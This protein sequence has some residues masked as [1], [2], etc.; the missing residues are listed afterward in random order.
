MI[1]YMAPPPEFLFPLQIL[2]ALLLASLM[3]SA[4]VMW[5]LRM[6]NVGGTAGNYF[7]M[8]FACISMYAVALI[9]QISARTEAEATIWGVLALLHGITGWFCLF[10]AGEYSV[11]DSPRP[12]RV[13]TVGTCYGM[14]LGGFIYSL[15]I[16]PGSGL[17]LVSYVAGYGWVSHV[18]LLFT[19]VIILS[20]FLSN[21]RFL[22]FV[23]KGYRVA[24]NTSFGRRSRT[25][26]VTLSI[27]LWIDF[28]TVG[29]G[30]I[31]WDY[32]IFSP[33]VLS[34]VSSVFII[35]AFFLLFRE[36]RIIYF[37]AQKAIGIIVLST[38]GVVYFDHKFQKEIE[39]N[40]IREFLGP[41]LTAVNNLVQETLDLAAIEWIREFQTDKMTFLLDVRAQYDIIGLLLV[42][43]PTQILRTA[44]R[45]FMDNLMILYETTKGELCDTPEKEKRIHEICVKA[46]P[47]I[48]PIN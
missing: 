16:S 36:Y 14:A 37:M 35:V 34:I 31:F 7:T 24:P 11:T 29:A 33:V 18:T 5:Y 12:M 39:N 26:L 17:V 15:L 20:G 4:A 1:M 45:K 19:L 42:S 40:A 32:A 28:I 22:Q 47:F 8:F 25:L 21:A 44:F 27:G 13:M 41:A 43:T 23:I 38:E 48:P 2:T 9:L 46:F 3:G 6:R 10:L 30:W